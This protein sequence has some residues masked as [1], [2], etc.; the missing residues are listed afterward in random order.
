MQG[1]LLLLL[2]FFFESKIFFIWFNS[3]I[4]NL[5]SFHRL[6]FFLY[7][8]PATVKVSKNFEYNF[9]FRKKRVFLTIRLDQTFVFIPIFSNKKNLSFIF[10]T[11]LN[12]AWSRYNNGMLILFNL[13]AVIKI[14]YMNRLCRFFVV[15]A[16]VFRFLR[17]YSII[18]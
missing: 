2:L 18:Y 9:F 3:I 16:S 12:N 8:I 7:H 11:E 13:L 14:V 1:L 10:I 6:H 15:V 4:K 17:L 5:D